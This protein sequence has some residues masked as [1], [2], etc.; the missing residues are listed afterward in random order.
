MLNLFRTLLSFEVAIERVR[1]VDSGIEMIV[2][3]TREY[4]WSYRPPLKRIYRCVGDG[5]E[6]R[7]SS[8][9]KQRKLPRWL[10]DEV[11]QQFARKV[12][13]EKWKQTAPNLRDVA[14]ATA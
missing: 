5:K 9:L 3:V 14:G 10:H 7:Y 12:I 11:N 4:T 13:E 8:G 6:W 1:P 2:T